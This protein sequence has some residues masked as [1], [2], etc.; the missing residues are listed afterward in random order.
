MQRSIASA[1]YE[2]HRGRF[3]PETSRSFFRPW[4]DGLCPSKQ[5]PRLLPSSPSPFL[6]E[7][8]GEGMRAVPCA[9]EASPRLILSWRYT[10]F[11]LPAKLIIIN[12][13]PSGFENPAKKSKKNILQVSN[14]R[15]VDPI[16]PRHV[17]ELKVSSRPI[18]HFC[19]AYHCALTQF[20]F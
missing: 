11:A 2:R 15:P 18:S 3:V 17:V 5:S 4:A 1:I 9:T 8:W 10:W 14:H 20:A 12:P 7:G 6:G 13:L 16:H 19:G